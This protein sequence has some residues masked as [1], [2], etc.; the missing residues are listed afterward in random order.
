VNPIE[1]NNAVWTVAG[2]FQD[3]A[4]RFLS[5][6]DDIIMAIIVFVIFWLIAKL[7]RKI[8]SNVAPRVKADTNAVLL[9]ARLAYAAVVIVG[10]TLALNASGVNWTAL[11]AGLGLTGFA[12]GFALKDAISNFLSGVLILFYR[13]F[14]IGDRVKVSS[15]EGVVQDIRV[16]DTIIIDKDGLKTIVPNSNVFG[17]VI[18]NYTESE[19]R[20]EQP[21]AEGL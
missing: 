6:V 12:L 11:A 20:P 19:P 18:I 16:R 15:I 4:E 9:V 2:I 14:K 21:P 3:I 7:V 1:S 5:K 17:N 8:I 10:V 13:P